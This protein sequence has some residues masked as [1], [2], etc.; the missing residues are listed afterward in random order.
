MKRP[1]LYWVILFILGEVLYKNVPIYLVGM[2]GSI[3]L[4]YVI[5]NRRLGRKWLLQLVGVAFFLLG[6]FCMHSWSRLTKLCEMNGNAKIEFSGRVIKREETG[7]STY[8][9]VKT[10]Y[11]NEEAVTVKMQIDIGEEHSLILGSFVY[12]SGVVKEF[13][14]ATNPGGYN[15]KA[16]K[17]G[18][19]I[20]SA[21]EQVEIYEEQRPCF[22]WREALDRFQRRIADVYAVLFDEKNASLASAMVL[23]DKKNL[24]SDIKELYQ[25][26]GIAHLIAISG[27]HIAMIGGTLYKLLRRTIGSYPVSAMVGAAFIIVYGVMTGL[28][29]A[30]FRA[31][32]MLLVSIGAD[33]TGRHYDGLTALSLALLVM[34]IENPYQFTQAGF[35][36]SFGAVLGIVLILPMWK[37]WFTKLPG[38]LEGWCVSVSVQLVLTPIM[39]YFFYEIPVYSILLN[40]IVVP[41]MNVLLALL[42]VCGILGG[43]SINL[44]TLPAI[45]AKLIF[46]LYEWLCRVSEVLPGHTF[47]TGKP[48]LWWLLIYYILL[49][50]IVWF[51]YQH[52][53]KKVVVVVM[54]FALLFGVF[55]LPTDVCICVF[56]VGQGDSIYIRTKNHQHILVDGGSNSQKKVGRYVLKN[57]IY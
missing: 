14:V 27:L 12:G 47:C 42:I 2:V 17:Q 4:I 46:S 9:I 33:V 57:V 37:S 40:V 43:A 35:L 29:G 19:G 16:Y 51:S 5:S 36:L 1:I 48:K 3:L 55:F 21:L 23:G 54:L 18:N 31:V 50:L 32:V 44:A 30:T 24:N 53:R 39:L 28:S 49:G 41:V 11:I 25:R 52:K 15:E 56:D 38:C 13:F 26:N 7:N 6:V 20:L 8:Y 10:R 45:V 22:A 34:L